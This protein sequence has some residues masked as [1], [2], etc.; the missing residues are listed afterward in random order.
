MLTGFPDAIRRPRKLADEGRTC[1]LTFSASAG[2]RP[3]C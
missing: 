1:W 3:W 2:L